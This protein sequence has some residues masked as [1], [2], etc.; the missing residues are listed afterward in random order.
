M[1]YSFRL[2]ARFLLY[3]PSNRRDS[4]YHGLCCSSRGVLAVTTNSSMSRPR[5][6]DP[7]TH[8][9]MSGLPTTVPTCRVI[10]VFVQYNTTQYNTI[11]HNKEL[12]IYSNLLLRTSVKRGSYKLGQSFRPRQKT[13]LGWEASRLSGYDIRAEG[14]FTPNKIPLTTIGTYLQQGYRSRISNN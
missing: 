8:R 5:G 7:T 4:T 12:R 1:G 6:I 2:A 11:Q 3:A 14:V 10:S 13:G 9:T